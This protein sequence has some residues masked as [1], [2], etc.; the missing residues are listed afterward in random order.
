MELTGW[1]R[2]P[3]LRAETLGFEEEKTL[4]RELSRTARKD[5]GLIVHAAGRSY[6]DSSLSPRVVLTDR[7]RD[8]LEFDPRT[9]HL[10]CEAGFTLAAMIEAFLPRGWFPATTPGDQVHHRGRGRG[11]RRPRQEP[12]PLRE[13]SPKAWTGWT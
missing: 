9:G 10:V 5:E 4:A 12:P 8:V 7:F 3:R 1:G 11:L 2:Y 6:G 13:P